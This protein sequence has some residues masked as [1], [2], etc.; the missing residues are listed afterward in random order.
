MEEI[1]KEKYV[2]DFFLLQIRNNPIRPIK[3]NLVPVGGV[4]INS[5]M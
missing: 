5:E 4:S 3:S 2:T 1:A